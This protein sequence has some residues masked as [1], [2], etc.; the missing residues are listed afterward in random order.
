M[1]MMNY[2]RK[3]TDSLEINCMNKKNDI[4]DNKIETG[5]V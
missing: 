2:S 5:T 4:A 1:D 3:Q